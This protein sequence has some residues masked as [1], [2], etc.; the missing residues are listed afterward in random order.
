MGNPG[1][2]LRTAL[3]VGQHDAPGPRMDVRVAP[4]G[5]RSLQIHCPRMLDFTLAVLGDGDRVSR[6]HPKFNLSGSDRVTHKLQIF[7]QMRRGS[8]QS[9]CLLKASKGV[10]ES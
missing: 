10:N 1:A 2:E 4:D 5:I 7:G 6:N 3:K 8:P 9:K